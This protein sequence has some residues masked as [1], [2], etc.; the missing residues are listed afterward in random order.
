MTA[1][2]LFHAGLHGISR[3]AAQ[4]RIEKELA[5]LGLGERSHEEDLQDSRVETA[6]GSSLRAH[7]SHE[8]R[9]C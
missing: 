4:S 7:S 1:N 3:G 2:L 5:R 9:L 6:G 8:P